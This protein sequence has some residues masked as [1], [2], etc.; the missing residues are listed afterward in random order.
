MWRCRHR[1]CAGG[2][3]KRLR[4]PAG[5]QIGGRGV[6]GRFVSAA[7]LAAVASEADDAGVLALLEVAAREADKAAAAQLRLE[8]KFQNDPKRYAKQRATAEAQREF[9]DSQ[10]DQISSLL[11]PPEEIPPE[12]YAV[13]WE[14]GFDYNGA[15]GRDTSDVDVNIRIAREDGEEMR[16]SEAVAALAELRAR[17][18]QGHT[19]PVPPGYRMA[20]INWRRP[21][22]GTGWRPRG[23]GSGT[24]DDLEAFSTLMYS[25]ADN[26]G[27]WSLSPGAGFRLGSV[28]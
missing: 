15:G 21:H 17:L 26:D 8:V 6:G 24:R 25:E 11:T 1:C 2:A 10:V 12:E 14:V 19:A 18:K 9:W 27:A 20:A 5:V 4:I 16:L 13:E 28:Q 3:V 22:S 7:Q 23:G